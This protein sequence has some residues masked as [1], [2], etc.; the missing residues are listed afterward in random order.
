MTARFPGKCAKTGAEIKK[1]DRVFY[2]PNGRQMFAGDAAEA[3]AADF[4]ACAADES[5]MTGNY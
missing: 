4:A 3:A 1:G 2:Y 5:F